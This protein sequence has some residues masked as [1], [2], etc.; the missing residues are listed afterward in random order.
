MG[1]LSGGTDCCSDVGG[2][3]EEVA[4]VA[5]ESG[6]LELVVESIIEG[7]DEDPDGCFDLKR[8]FTIL[9]ILSLFRVDITLTQGIQ[10]GR[11]IVVVRSWRRSVWGF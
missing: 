9:E 10:K 6:S 8:F 4:A 3:S 1:S 7:S 5:Q 2:H 11:V